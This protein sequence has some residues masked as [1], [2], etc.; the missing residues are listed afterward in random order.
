[1]SQIFPLKQSLLLVFVMM[2]TA[3]NTGYA[4]SNQAIKKYTIAQI[5]VK[6]NSRDA[7]MIILRSGLAYGDEI[8]IPGDDISKAIKKLWSASLFSDIQ[9]YVEKIEG[10]KIALAIEVVEKEQINAFLI[11]GIKKSEKEDLEEL[12]KAILF[13]SH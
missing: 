5:D 11:E 7:A 9:I 12:L 8:K 3:S 2:L 13:K 10:D 4:Q 1:M 6:G